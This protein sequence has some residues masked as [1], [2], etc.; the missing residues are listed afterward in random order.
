M[1]QR[2]L[3]NWVFWSYLVVAL[4]SFS[5]D[6]LQTRRFHAAMR[7]ARLCL[8]REDRACAGPQIE[9]ARH[10]RTGDPSLK[11]AEASLRLQ[12]GA[13][14]RAEEA[15]IR[16]EQAQGSKR[17]ASSTLRADIL[18]LRGDLAAQV[19]DHKNAREHYKAAQLL[20]EDPALVNIRMARL[21][22]LDENERQR[23][24]SEIALFREDFAAL[25]EAAR[26]GESNI[27][28]LRA[29]EVYGWIARVANAEVRK[30]LELAT[31]GARQALFA[32]SDTPQTYRSS[33]P[34]EPTKPV[35]TGSRWSQDSYGYAME[36]YRARLAEYEK[37]KAKF[38][39]E[40]QAQA[41]EAAQALGAS[42]REAQRLFEDAVRALNESPAML[43]PEAIVTPRRASGYAPSRWPPP[44]RR[45]SQWAGVAP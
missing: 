6:A 4:A 11:L 41:T 26:A 40:Q 33:E 35:H 8:A 19:K 1:Q 12:L 45:I 20:V 32:A 15:L 38:D 13:T 24:L 27:A 14:T 31:E 9:R 18:L 2:T 34:T 3:A 25:I 17:N 43:R 16:I 36:N 28:N 37:R 7:E 10:V 21:D 42:V 23:A 39:Q 22:A 29:D 30:Q 44:R 5:V